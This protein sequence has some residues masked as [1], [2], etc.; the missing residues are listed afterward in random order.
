LALLR[1]AFPS[2]TLAQLTSALTEFAADLG[3]FGPDN[4]YGN[5]LVDAAAAF[6]SLVAGCVRPQVDF[7]AAPF[8]ASVNQQITFTSTVSGGTPPYSYAW[9]FNGD[10]ATDCTDAVCS[11]IYTST[12]SGAVSLTVTDSNGC[13]SS[14]IVANGWAACTPISATFRFSPLSPLPGEPVTFTGS[15]AGGTLPYTFEWDMNEDGLT[16]C[17]ANVCTTIYP[18]VYNGSV[19]LWVTDRYGCQADVYSA[20]IS[21]AASPP[22]PN[23]GASG[24]GGGGGGCFIA[25]LASGHGDQSHYLAFA[26]TLVGLGIVVLDN[27]AR[28]P[29]RRTRGF[30]FDRSQG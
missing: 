23:S 3:D 12:Y 24:S 10:D 5:G 19:M 14:I 27:R 25:A 7:S 21:V 28:R 9:D 30:H 26:F 4:V 13:S 15:V 16:D 1:S 11:Q 17:T 20:G 2:A 8:P 6:S 18:A 29:L 22:S